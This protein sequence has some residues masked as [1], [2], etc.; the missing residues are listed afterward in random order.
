MYNYPKRRYA[1]CP[2]P[3]LTCDLSFKNLQIWR[4]SGETSARV[5]ATIFQEEAFISGLLL[6]LGKLLERS[7]QNT[8]EM[9]VQSEPKINKQMIQKPTPRGVP[10]RLGVALKGSWA[11]LGGSW[12]WNSNYDDFCLI[13]LRV[14]GLPWG[15]LGAQDGRLGGQDDP[16]IFAKTTHDAS[17]MLPRQPKIRFSRK[18]WEKMSPSSSDGIFHSI[19]IR[20]QL[21]NTSPNFEKSLKLFKKNMHF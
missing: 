15:R 8:D 17:K 3:R 7:S 21:K 10:H 6:A 5:A 16:K 18:K 4:R 12:A 2:P 19:L 11:L 9:E 1:A 20:F 13:F 14:L